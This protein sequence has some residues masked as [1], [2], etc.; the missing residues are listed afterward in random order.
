MYSEIQ[1]LVKYYVK[2]F[3][4]TA[5]AKEDVLTIIS[6][7]ETRTKQLVVT[8]Q[9]SIDLQDT[10]IKLSEEYKND[11]EQTYTNTAERRELENGSNL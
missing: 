8:Q 1:Y 11:I 5:V 4:T 6:A 9:D 7:I 3:A 2:S 10:I